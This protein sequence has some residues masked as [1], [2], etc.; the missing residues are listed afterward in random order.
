M[1]AIASSLAADSEPSTVILTELIPAMT[2]LVAMIQLN[3]QL[4]PATYGEIYHQLVT[5]VNE[6]NTTARARKT[7]KQNN[8]EPE[9]KTEPV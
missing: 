1:S 2:N 7:R 4:D 3:N 6:I 8:N 5:Y 9:P